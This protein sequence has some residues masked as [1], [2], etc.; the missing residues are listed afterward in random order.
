MAR[1]RPKV[2]CTCSFG[3]VVAQWCQRPSMPM[4]AG[5]A[6]GVVVLEIWRFSLSAAAPSAPS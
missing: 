6:V 5:Y 3:S 4:S 2:G 1:G